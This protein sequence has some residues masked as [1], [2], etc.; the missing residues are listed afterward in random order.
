MTLNLGDRAFETSTTQGT[1]I[2]NLNGPVM[3]FVSFV[4]AVGSGKKVPY[5]ISDNEDWET[6][7]GTVTAGTP[8]TL[9]RTN[10]RRS[11]NANAAVDWGTGTRNVRLGVPADY[12][13]SRDEN[14]N[15]IEGF[16]TGGGTANA[17]TVTLPVVPLAYSDGME[18]TYFATVAN[19]GAMTLNVNSLGAKTVKIRG[20]D[21]PAGLIQIGT[22]VKV[23]FRNNVFELSS[24]VMIKATAAEVAA[25]TA[26]RFPDAATLK[27]PSGHS[28]SRY[29][30]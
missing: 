23:T 13:P 12:T 15:F 18:I 1:G 10:I 14:M 6:G 22:L 25:E 2:I 4:A 21:L 19:T 11:S 8:D 5:I 30:V 7:Y 24:P 26:N 28:Q 9:S 16:G 20:E 17:Q 3:G 27:K 29:Q